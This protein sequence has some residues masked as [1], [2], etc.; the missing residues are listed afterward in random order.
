ML[1]IDSNMN[2]GRVYLPLITLSSSFSSDKLFSQ[3]LAVEHVLM[4]PQKLNDA[5]LTV[6]PYHAFNQPSACQALSNPSP[7]AQSVSSDDGPEG[8]VDILDSVHPQ[9]SSLTVDGTEIRSSQQTALAT[10]NSNMRFIDIVDTDI[11]D[12][13]EVMPETHLVDITIQDSVKLKLFQMSTLP[14]DIH[15]THPNVNMQILDDTVN[16]TGPDKQALELLKTTIVNL[17][18]GMAQSTVTLDVEMAR[19]L[20]HEDVREILLQT[21]TQLG[22]TA[23]YTVSNKVVVVTALSQD[24][25]TQGCVSL[26][27]QLCTICI[28]VQK[29]FECMLYSEEWSAFLQT[30]GL[31]SVRV[32]EDGANVDVWTLKGFEDEKRSQVTEFLLTPIEQEKFIAMEPG[33]LK[34][35]QMYF[36]QLMAEMNQVVI[37]PI[38]GKD[39]CGL[40]V[41][42]TLTSN[43]NLNNL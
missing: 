35:V 36:H 41:C 16:L 6:S 34:Y 5:T 24:L 42:R 12:V 19:F 39:L 18:A 30:L 3:F 26:T 43:T 17:F 10:V 8:Q 13:T 33:M 29:E 27:S 9:A 25:A 32:S 22:I 20:E 40:R 28:P 31:C 15:Q 4:H 23:I 38:D 2:T 11:K 14:H 7:S 1:G 37:L 21:F